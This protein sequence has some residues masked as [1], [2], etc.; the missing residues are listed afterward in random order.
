MC[1][2]KWCSWNMMLEQT[3]IM[4][5][6]MNAKLIGHL[7]LWFYCIVQ[8]DFKSMHH[9]HSLPY[10][11]PFTPFIF[12][13]C[14][15]SFNSFLF[16]HVRWKHI[17]GANLGKKKYYFE[18]K[19]NIILGVGFLFFLYLAFWVQQIKWIFD[20]RFLTQFMLPFKG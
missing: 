19:F 20:S 9:V 17:E 2:L 15:I 12:S 13:L 1:L 8:H 11:F 18:N 3:W 10:F 5:V 16:M 14:H 4:L 6:K 7:G